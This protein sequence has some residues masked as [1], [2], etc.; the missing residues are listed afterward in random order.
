ME[1]VKPKSKKTRTENTYLNT[2]L[3]VQIF[4]AIVYLLLFLIS[5][6]IALLID[7]PHKNDYIFT[8]ITFSLCSFISAFYS[9]IKMKHNGLAVGIVFTLPMNGI[10]MLI[11]F[12]ISDFKA[13]YMFVVSVAVLIVT[14]AI[15]GILAVNK[16]RRR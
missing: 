9:G 3:N 5:S 1:K 2:F 7:L 14:S 16:R 11:S 4:D 13:D 12:I 6:S 10:T 8:L 15:G